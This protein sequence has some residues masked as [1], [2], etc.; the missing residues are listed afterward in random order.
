MMNE[1]T[2]FRKGVA[3]EQL[4]KRER[5]RGHRQ[6]VD[7]YTHLDGSRKRSRAVSSNSSSSSISTISTN[8]SRS[9]LPLKFTEAKHETTNSSHAG[10]GK[11]RRRS[12]SSSMTYT[13]ES[14]VE[15]R[16]P[17]RSSNGG[18]NTRRRRSS[19]SP[20]IRGR[21]RSQ[22][23]T[24]NK[25]RIDDQKRRQ[26][27]RSSSISCSSDTSF[28][29]NRRRRTRDNQDHRENFRSSI[30]P[31][32][33]GRDRNYFGKRSNRRTRSRSYSRDRSRVARNRHS[34]TPGA[35][36]RQIKRHS[37]L[38]PAKTRGSW[39]FND[40]DRYGSSIRGSGRDNSRA[41]RSAKFSE[42]PPKERSLSPFSKRLALTQAMNIG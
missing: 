3:D 42:R 41:P 40:N 15:K 30:S 27:S 20:N 5:E 4:A 38:S 36:P 17:D 18:R 9:P 32:S 35:P 22:D 31:D 14:S 29:T 1:L 34:M 39:S 12:T 2:I 28:E 23:R 37:E 13:S 10:L 19:M 21:D 25:G 6:K 11:R 7:E 26:N 24:V 16:R 33:R 8:L